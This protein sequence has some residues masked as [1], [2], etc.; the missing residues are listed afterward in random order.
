MQNR[1]DSTKQK[2]EKE[3]W[4][5]ITVGL[6]R[7]CTVHGPAQLLCR[8]PPCHRVSTPVTAR[9]LVGQMADTATLQGAVG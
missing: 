4:K 6:N 7:K 9:A 5:R 2:I 1:G 3:K 8:L